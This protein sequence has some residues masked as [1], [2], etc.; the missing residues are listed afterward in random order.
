MT[1]LRL[2]QHR[3]SVQPSHFSHDVHIIDKY[4]ITDS[5][6]YRQHITSQSQ[7]QAW[8]Q[9]KVQAHRADIPL[10]TGHPGYRV[11]EHPESDITQQSGTHLH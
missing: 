6:L 7:Q 3:D 9:Q 4:Q 10:R 11:C 1:Y 8:P 5:H 2:R